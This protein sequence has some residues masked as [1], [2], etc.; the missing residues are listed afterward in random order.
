MGAIDRLWHEWFEAGEGK[1]FARLIA[2]ILA[3][4]VVFGLVFAVLS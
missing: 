1:G 2:F 4:V 3:F